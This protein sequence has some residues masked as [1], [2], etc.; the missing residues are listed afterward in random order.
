MALCRCV[1]GAR[2]RWSGHRVHL[3]AGARQHRQHH[4]CASRCAHQNI[5]RARRVPAWLPKGDIFISRVW[6]KRMV[7]RCRNAPLAYLRDVVAGNMVCDLP[8]FFWRCRYDILQIQTRAVLS[9]LK[10]VITPNSR[11]TSSGTKTFRNFLQR[12]LYDRLRPECELKNAHRSFLAPALRSISAR[13]S[14]RR[15]MFFAG[16]DAKK[17]P[18]SASRRAPI[19]TF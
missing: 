5:S 19:C 15:L 6:Q 7:T 10:I 4:F 9:A 12:K 11:S 14:C 2:S 17:A 18:A 16:S 1:R 8:C 13:S 3:D